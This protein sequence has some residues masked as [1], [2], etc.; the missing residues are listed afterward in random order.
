[1]AIT[2]AIVIGPGQF[3]IFIEFALSGTRSAEIAGSHVA[4]A[5]MKQLTA[6]A[7]TN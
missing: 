2:H 4:R 6:H 3:T 5:A 1:M 7:E